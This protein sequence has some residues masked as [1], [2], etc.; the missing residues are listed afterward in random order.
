MRKFYYVFLPIFLLVMSC[1]QDYVMEIKKENGAIT[2]QVLPINSGATVEL[3]QGPL[4]K[5]T[6]VDKDGY[7][8][9]DDL[10]IGYYSIVAY[11]NGFGSKTK[12]SIKVEEGAVNDIGRLTLSL[13]NSL[14]S[15][16]EPADKSTNINTTSTIRIYF[17][18]SMDEGSVRSAF[19]IQPEIPYDMTYSTSNYF[20]IKATMDF[21]TTYTISIDTTAKTLS[22]EKL[23]FKFISSFTTDH[24]RL[25]NMSNLNSSLMAAAQ[26]SFYYSGALKYSQPMDF[27]SV[28][29]E[30]DLT[31]KIS[32]STLYFYPKSCWIS[33]TEYHI[34][35]GKGI[36]ST[37]GVVIESDTS[38]VFKTEKLS[39]ID[40]VP[41]DGQNFIPCTTNI[42]FVFNYSIDESTILDALEI[43]P[44]FNYHITTRRSSGRQYITIQ[45]DSLDAETEYHISFS[46]EL[47]DIYGKHL[48]KPFSLSFVTEP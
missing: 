4:L 38:F 27:I 37:N 36:E 10:K 1:Q 3:H 28:T 41:Y 11:S 30:T 40:A 34:T 14:I 47:T 45:P 33:D 31:F 17:T 20:Y 9:F 6:T 19:S 44:E 21:K 43:S 12:I 18:D 7:F 26:I 2:G 23:Q 22:G 48:S 29:P 46:E 5:S 39:V 35:V 16:I 42:N 32:S 15:S 13:S 8:Y 24:F 25:T